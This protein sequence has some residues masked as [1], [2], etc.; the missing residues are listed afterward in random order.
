VL[1]YLTNS[2]F[3][4]AS[5]KWSLTL[6]KWQCMKTWLQHTSY[7]SYL[8]KVISWVLRNNN[9]HQYHQHK[10]PTATTQHSCQCQ[11]QSRFIGAY[12]CKLAFIALH[13]LF[14]DFMTLWLQQANHSS[15]FIQGSSVLS[16]QP[17]QNLRVDCAHEIVWDYQLLTW[18]IKCVDIIMKMMTIVTLTS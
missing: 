5:G 9:A 16:R 11:C 13:M 4:H 1:K 12:I 3:E 15:Q 10:Q 2:F 17:Q 6:A 7:L 8:K 14:K 18:E